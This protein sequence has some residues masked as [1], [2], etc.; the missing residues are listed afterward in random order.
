MY[1]YMA[2]SIVRDPQPVLAQRWLSFLG[3]EWPQCF[4]TLAFRWHG[5]ATRRNVGGRV[6]QTLWDSRQICTAD[7]FRRH[8]GLQFERLFRVSCVPRTNG[9]R[10]NGTARAVATWDAIS[11]AFRDDGSGSGGNCLCVQCV[12]RARFDVCKG[13]GRRISKVLTATGGVLKRFRTASSR[14]PT[15]LLRCAANF[16]ESS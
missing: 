15:S 2:S 12:N 3:L 14:A 9:A 4:D 5:L 6:S 11:G 16:E 10:S 1:N 8:D 13:Q 7:P